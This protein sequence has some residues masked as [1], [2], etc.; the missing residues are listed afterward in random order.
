MMIPAQAKA[1]AESLHAG[2]LDSAGLPEARHLAAV[3][4]QVPED[5]QVVAWLHD[6]PE[7]GLV[8][9][10]ALCEE[11]VSEEDI[12][13]L[14]LLDRSL[15]EGTY[16][17]YIRSICAA[18]GP[19]GAKARRVKHADNHENKERPLGSSPGGMRLPGGRY[20]R[21]LALLEESMRARGELES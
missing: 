11:G 13:A 3:A 6:A 1:L 15:W 21:A 16:M 20:E 9:Y 12:A 19:S 4:A 14:R 5:C 18:P 2:R 10:E 17:D 8:T 7:E